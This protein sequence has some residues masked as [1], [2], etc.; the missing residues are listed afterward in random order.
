MSRRTDTP[1][2]AALRDYG[3]ALRRHR[4]ARR[5]LVG[6]AALTGMGCAALLLTTASP[7]MPRLLW[8]ASASAPIGLY[9]VSRDRAIDVGDMVI[10]WPPASVRAIAAA[11]RYLP[12][13]VPLV[14]RVAAG[15]GDRICAAGSSIVIDG[16]AVASRRAVDRHSR[17]LP[18]WSGCRTLRDHHYLL[19]MADVADSFDG[20]YFGI[21]NGSEIIGR[22]RLLWRR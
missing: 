5:R 8:N 2:E 15:P 22:A 16:R 13:G 21:T 12:R 3:D 9:R 11:R 1:S 19:L 10:A 14:K 4:A 17:P 7:P 20:R 18:W 6:R